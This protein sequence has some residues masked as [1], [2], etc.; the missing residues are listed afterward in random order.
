MTVARTAAG[1][2]GNGPAM[3]TCSSPATAYVVIGRRAACLDSPADAASYIAGCA[4]SNDVSERAF[5]LEE[6]TT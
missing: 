1:S 2:A 6:S 5:Q 3:P 4:V